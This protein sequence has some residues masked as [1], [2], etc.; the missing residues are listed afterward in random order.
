M[1]IAIHKGPAPPSQWVPSANLRFLR[2]EQNSRD[3]A[4]SCP[5][6]GAVLDLVQVHEE[7]L[8]RIASPFHTIRIGG[9]R[10]KIKGKDGSEI[11]IEE[12]VIA[13]VLGSRQVLWA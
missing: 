6:R 11:D 13:N 5:D 3:L 10:P 4:L 12:R 1:A 2:I 9:L 8:A 7:S